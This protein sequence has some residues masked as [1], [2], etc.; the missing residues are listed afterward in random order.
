MAGGIDAERARLEAAQ[1]A[2]QQQL[3]HQQMQAQIAYNAQASEA[4]RAKLYLFISVFFL[5]KSIDAEMIIIQKH[6]N[7]I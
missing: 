3:A 5:L 6:L 7:S 4:L 1:K 2:A